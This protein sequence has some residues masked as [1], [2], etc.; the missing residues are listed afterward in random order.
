MKTN[1]NTQK[2]WRRSGVRTTA[3]L[4][5]LARSLGCSFLRCKGTHET[6]AT[7]GGR[8]FGIHATGSRN[9]KEPSR[10]IVTNFFRTLKEE[11]ISLP[12]A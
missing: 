1:A 6:W 10:N 8:R 9:D 5:K 3:D 7:P 4:V 2:G 11:G 12:A